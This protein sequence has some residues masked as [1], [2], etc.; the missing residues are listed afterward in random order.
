MT[1]IGLLRAARQAGLRIPD[2]LAVIGF[3][4][5]PIA[6]YVY[7]ALTTVAQPKS[8]LGQRAMAMA[9]ALRGGE[10]DAVGDLILPG[11]LVIREST[12]ALLNPRSAIDD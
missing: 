1:A 2:D 10:T 7:P 12:G 3:D 5:I 8:E 11:R 9:M 4:D 6:A